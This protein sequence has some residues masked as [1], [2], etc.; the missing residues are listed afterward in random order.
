MGKRGSARGST[1]AVGERLQR[2]DRGN[3]G[4]RIAGTGDGIEKS[5]QFA[6]STLDEHA[7]RR[8]QT[9]SA[10]QILY[11]GVVG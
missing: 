6:K 4:Q 10:K 9:R 3:D 5:Q 8:R 1:G 11:G 7:G 2:V